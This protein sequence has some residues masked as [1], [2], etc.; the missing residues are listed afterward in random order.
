MASVT[1]YSAFG[2]QEKKSVTVS[3]VSPPIC[4]EVMGPNGEQIKNRIPSAVHG[5]AESDTI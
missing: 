2:S 4:H 3:I 1:I 5:V